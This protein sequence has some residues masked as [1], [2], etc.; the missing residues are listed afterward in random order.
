MELRTLIFFITSRCNAKCRTCFYWKELNGKHDLT[1]EEIDRI[2]RTMPR[3]R[4]LWLSGG[5]PMMRRRLGEIV[6]FFYQRNAVRTLNLPS[7]GLFE[8]RTVELMEF[9]GREMPDM[10]VNLNLALDG[11]AET[12]DRIRQV[13]GNF[14]KAMATIEALYAIREAY[15]N[16]RLHVNSV[17]T[18]ENVDELEEL[19]WWLVDQADLDGH[20]FQVI[21]GEAKDPALKRLDRG[22]VADLYRQVRPI[23]GHYAERLRRRHGGGIRGWLKKHYYN[24]TILFHYTIQERNL[25]GPNAWPM[26]CTA[27]RTIAVI[28]ANGDMRACEL[29]KPI[30]NLRDVDCDFSKVFPSSELERETQNIVRDQCWC[31]H[32]CF[33]HESLKSSKRAKLYEVPLAPKVA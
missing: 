4:E 19:G 28:D 2:S 14:E 30:R 32:V 31:T 26:A 1:F 3:F 24:Q 15:P 25:E 27:G 6:A 12:H 13:P 9:V 11:F 29:R 21:R 7:N 8:R 5:E 16:I 10:D 22:G 18:S 23:H 33:I 17:A 20:Y